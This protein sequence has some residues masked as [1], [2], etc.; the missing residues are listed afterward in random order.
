M[1]FI[2]E[3]WKSNI[4]LGLSGSMATKWNSFC[5][6]LI[7]SG[8]HLQPRDDILIWTGG[9]HSGILSVKNVYN[10]LAKKLWP[11]QIAGWRRHLWTWDLAWEGPS[12]CP[13]C[14][15][16]SETALHLFV[17]CSFTH[18]LWQF[19][20][21]VFS[22]S[23]PWGGSSL[24]N[25]LDTW[26]KKEKVYI[27]LPSL[28]CWYIWLERNKCLFESRIPSIQGVAIKI[29]GMVENS[30]A[31]CPRKRKSTRI[32]KTPDF[33][34]ASIC[35]FDGATQANGLLS[36]VGGVIKLSGNIVYRWTLNCGSGT[37]TRVELLGVW[38][39]LTL[40]YRLGID[41]LQVLGDSKIVIDWLNFRGNLQVTS[42]VGWMDKILDLIKSFNTI[43]FDHIYREENEEAD[44]LSKKS[45]QVPEGKI[46]YNKWQDGHEGPHYF[47]P[48]SVTGYHMHIW[49]VVDILLDLDPTF[50][51]V[52]KVTM[53]H[54]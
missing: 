25:C 52:L 7:D 14:Y 2:T 21:T 16:D 35:W 37:N 9:D 23:S 8:I 6:A 18:H 44:A 28:A 49:E 20:H 39:S 33:T 17:N 47:A 30:F 53:F 32:K 41:Q 15:R 34:L 42:L 22:L 38:A 1:G 26:M 40:A 10:A 48:L 50:T 4:E 36:G 29:R 5:K 13:L 51:S 11:Q 12:I 19:L 31:Q 45:L 27:T 24:T 54:F 3:Q 46:H 43:R